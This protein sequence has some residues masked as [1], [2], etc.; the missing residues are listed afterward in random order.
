MKRKLLSLLV[1]F[2]LVFNACNP[3]DD[4]S[5]NGS[6][7]EQFAQNFGAAVARDFIGQI[8]DSDHHPVSGATVSIGSSA[9]QTDENGIFILNDAG[10]H[11][12]FAYITAEKAGFI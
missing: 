7:D 1:I 11:E 5:G 3:G 12:K 10:V 2:S 4:T 8:I 6:G 9:V